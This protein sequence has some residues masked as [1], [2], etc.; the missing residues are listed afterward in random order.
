MHT[1]SNS[2]FGPSR[3]ITFFQNA[4]PLG[5]F[6]VSLVSAGMDI[7][8][9]IASGPKHQRIHL[10]PLASSSGCRLCCR[11][12]PDLPYPPGIPLFWAGRF[13][14]AA[15]IFSSR[16]ERELVEMQVHHEL[17]HDFTLMISGLLVCGKPLPAALWYDYVCCM[18]G[19]IQRFHNFLVSQ[20]MQEVPAFCSLGFLELFRVTT[21]LAFSY[22]V[23]DSHPLFRTLAS[24][25][26][27]ALHLLL[28]RLPQYLQQR[29]HKRSRVE[30]FP[31][32]P[33]VAL[34]ILP[35]VDLKAAIATYCIKY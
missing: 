31:T 3:S 11:M 1:L 24:R 35:R 5:E 7:E 22:R 32:I 6:G 9:S 25:R 10:Q 2:P 13:P 33:L 14:N 17:R 19:V 4:P 26:P 28:C 23:M 16:S 12:D 30:I 18:A 8:Q 15:R 27:V 34:T 20:A 29:L 21:G